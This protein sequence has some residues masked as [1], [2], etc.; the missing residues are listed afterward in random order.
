MPPHW[1]EDW[2]LRFASV[3]IRE[4]GSF[5]EAF[6]SLNKRIESNDDEIQ[7]SPELSAFYACTLVVIRYLEGISWGYSPMLIHESLDKDMSLTIC[8]TFNLLQ[9]IKQIYR[10]DKIIG[11]EVS[12]LGDIN[13]VYCP[14][15][16]YQK[17][18]SLNQLDKIVCA[19]SQEDIDN[20]SGYEDRHM[21]FLRKQIFRKTYVAGKKKIDEWLRSPSYF[22]KKGPFD[23][24]GSETAAL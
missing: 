24:E 19:S 6:E 12:K 22:S 4:I 5:A 18:F 7:R 11:P 2:Y 14:E 3:L 1:V 17:L 23:T 16:V 20:L 10:E 8:V 21:I 13:S 15:P 9:R